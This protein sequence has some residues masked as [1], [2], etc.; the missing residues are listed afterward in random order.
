MIYQYG[1]ITFNRL[2]AP[3]EMSIVGSMN[4]QQMER[5][6]GKPV[7]QKV[8]IPLRTIDMNIELFYQVTDV[9]TSISKLWAKMYA[10]VE[11]E[12]IDGNGF[13][14]GTFVINRIQQEQRKLDDDGAVLSATMSLSFL[15]YAPYEQESAEKLKAR[16]NAFAVIEAKPI[17]VKPRTVYV[18]PQAKTAMG[19]TTSVTATKASIA[20]VKKA[21]QIPAMYDKYMN[22][23]K[24]QIKTAQTGLA[25]ARS[26][27]D[28]VTAQVSN[29]A[30]LK[31]TIENTISLTTQMANSLE[32]AGP[33]DLP[34]IISGVAST[35]ESQLRNLMSSAAIITAVTSIRQ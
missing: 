34:F 11:E 6:T 13:S 3:S 32:S 22:Q 12:L 5:V 28:K 25:E 19:I 33:E 8:G 31:T 20:N 26:Q 4:Y 2:D 30:Q 9:T 14:Y 21:N 10:G 7:L 23:A 24:R 35:T 17:E 15:E 27:V 16:K 18:T 29:I 1:D